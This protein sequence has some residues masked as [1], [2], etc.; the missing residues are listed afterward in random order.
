MRAA[1]IFMACCFC[2]C[3]VI[4]PSQK[5]ICGIDDPAKQSN[6]CSNIMGVLACIVCVGSIA[7]I[8]MKK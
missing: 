1:V 8:L 7:A 4:G 3:C 6:T 5:Y 2:L